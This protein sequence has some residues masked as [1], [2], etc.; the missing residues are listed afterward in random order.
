MPLIYGEGN[1]AFYRMQKDIMKTTE[2]YTM[3]AWGLATNLSNKHNYW[4][5][6]QQR[7]SFESRRPLADSPNDFARHDRS[8]WTY[9]QLIQDR[10]RTVAAQL[11]SALDDTPPLIT[12]RGLRVSL[13]LKPARKGRD[14]VLAYINCNTVRPGAPPGTP[15]SPVCLL[16]QRQGG[17]NI[18]MGSDDPNYAFEL[19][20]NDK[21]LASFERRTIYLSL[22]SSDSMST[23]NL[24]MRS[25]EKHLYILDKPTDPRSM[26][27][28]TS[29]FS[30]ATGTGPEHTH[31]EAPRRFNLA[32]LHHPFDM[33][34]SSCRLFA[35]E[36]L[37]GRGASFGIL[38]GFGWCDVVALDEAFRDKWGILVR[39]G[40][41]NEALMLKYLNYAVESVHK[42]EGQTPVDRVVK[43]IGDLKVSVSLKKIR[44]NDINSESAIK[45]Q[46]SVQ[47]V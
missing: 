41:W 25:L 28:I 15:R 35:F 42:S 37:Q 9:G 16:L 45:I 12:S 47:K 43:T 39:D 17:T 23:H 14:A 10:A 26:W 1:R 7:S 27:K 6:P 46:W 18:Y 29:C 11:S 36:P 31:Y 44:R 2:D 21:A 20:D 34:P 22:A 19:L 24:R 3:L 30:H 40:H 4:K 33:G 5:S 13:L 32:T 38:V 8:Q